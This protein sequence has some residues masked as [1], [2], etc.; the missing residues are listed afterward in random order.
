MGTN[1][2]GIGTFTR[3]P[4]SQDTPSESCQCWARCLLWKDLPIFSLDS[5][6]SHSN[7]G[8]QASPALVLPERTWRPREVKALPKSLSQ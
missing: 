1:W 6:E 8:G 7:K 5:P 3:Q 4:L 2:K